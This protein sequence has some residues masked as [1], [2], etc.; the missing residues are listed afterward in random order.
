M[1]LLLE[2]PNGYREVK[3][4]GIKREVSHS[5]PSPRKHRTAVGIL[6]EDGPTPWWWGPTHPKSKSSVF[7]FFF[8]EVDEKEVF[9]FFP[10]GF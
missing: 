3:W 6:G 7:F 2:L 4:E 9:F 1:L 10:K 8:C 5:E